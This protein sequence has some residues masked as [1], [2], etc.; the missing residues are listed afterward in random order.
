MCI[1][2]RM[3]TVAGDGVDA[4]MGEGT[5]VVVRAEVAAVDLTGVDG[6]DVYKRQGL[7]QLKHLGALVVISKSEGAGVV[8]RHDHI[9]D[10]DHLVLE[11]DVYKRQL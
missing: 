7:G 2:D 3:H 10:V 8:E 6:G 5:D 4:H 9:A 11:V 1:R